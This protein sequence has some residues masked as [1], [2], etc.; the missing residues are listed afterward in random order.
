MSAVA[1]DLIFEIGTEELPPKNVQNLAEN[2]ASLFSQGLKEHGLKF[3]SVSHYASPRRIAVSIKNLAMQQDDQLIERRGP[4]IKA[5]YDKEGNPSKALQG[6]ARSCGVEP[7]QLNTLETEQGSWL[8]FSKTEAGKETKA[9]FP[10]IAQAS[11]HQLPIAKR[12]N[13]GSNKTG[14]VRPVHWILFLHGDQV[15]HCELLGKQAGNTTHGH[16]FHHPEAICIPSASEYASRLE[17][18]GGV[19]ADFEVRKARIK[20]QA[21]QAV[22]QN[23]QVIIDEDLLN[24]VT[25]LVEQPHTLLGHFEESFLEV[26]QEALISAMQEHQKH[27]LILLAGAN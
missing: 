12:M 4:S 19:I 5:A 17:N 11:I 27:F 15:V 10:A 26:P 6:F 22:N 23:Q 2:L 18:S 13:W 14:F 1:Q 21:L 7:N 8:V 16:R 9:L 25:G 20:E 24:E 3:D